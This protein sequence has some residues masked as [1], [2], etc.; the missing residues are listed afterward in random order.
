MFY[1]LNFEGRRGAAR[2]GT[3]GVVTYSEGSIADSNKAYTKIYASLTFAHFCNFYAL[4]FAGRR[5][6]SSEGSDGIVTYVEQLESK[7]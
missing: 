5:G 4:N 1:A 3:D 2:N 6:K 7:I